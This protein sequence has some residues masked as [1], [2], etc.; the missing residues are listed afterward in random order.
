MLSKSALIAPTFDRP[1]FQAKVFNRLTPQCPRL[2]Y[3]ARR[4]K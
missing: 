2:G 1:G 3:A 4:K